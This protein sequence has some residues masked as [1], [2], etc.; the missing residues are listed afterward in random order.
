MQAAMS[1]FSTGTTVAIAPASAAEP[2]WAVMTEA[3]SSPA[4]AAR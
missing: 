4:A 3:C 1:T 2:A